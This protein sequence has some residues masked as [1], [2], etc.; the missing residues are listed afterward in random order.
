M[1]Y[2]YTQSYWNWS[3][4]QVFKVVGKAVSHQQQSSQCQHTTRPRK[5]AIFWLQGSIPFKV[6]SSNQ[7]SLFSR[8]VPKI[9]RRSAIQT[10]ISWAATLVRESFFRRPFFSVSVFSFFSWVHPGVP[11]LFCYVSF[12]FFVV[13]GLTDTLETQKLKMCPAP[14]I[15]GTY[16]ASF[17]SLLSISL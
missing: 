5:S 13:W 1:K 4:G 14:Q 6:E 7:F 2:K 17:I 11:L 15:C 10:S 8:T 12:D 3:L 16:Q 9:E